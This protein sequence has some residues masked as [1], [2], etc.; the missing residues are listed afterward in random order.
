MN[1]KLLSMNLTFRIA[2]IFLLFLNIFELH[3]QQPPDFEAEKAAGIFTYD[4]D[5]VIQKLKIKDKDIK[6]SISSAIHEYNAKMY[7]LSIDHAATFSELD[8]YFDRQV[9]LAMQYRDKS[10]MDGVKADIQKTIPP[11]RREVMKH[12][13]VLNALMESVL[14]EKQLKKWLNYQKSSKPSTPL[15]GR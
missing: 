15:A 1:K 5:K 10:Q 13:Q 7:Q 2:T 9:K 3:A 14:D 6:Q 11:I 8:A 12:E 4:I